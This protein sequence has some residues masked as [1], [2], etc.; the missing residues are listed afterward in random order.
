MAVL[1]VCTSQATKPFGVLDV[2]FP[3]DEWATLYRQHAESVMCSHRLVM[4]D[5]IPSWDDVIEYQTPSG[6]VRFG[7]ERPQKERHHA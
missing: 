6:V 1:D 3:S 7:V 4:P 2:W 5:E